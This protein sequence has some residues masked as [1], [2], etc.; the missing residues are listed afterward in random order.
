M[1]RRR[2]QRPEL[3]RQ[4]TDGLDQRDVV[5]G[6]VGGQQRESDRGSVAVRAVPHQPPAGVPQTFPIR[7][8]G[9]GNDVVVAMDRDMDV[10]KGVDK[11]VRL[12]VRPAEMPVE[13]DSDIGPEQP[14]IPRPPG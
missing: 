9:R 6:A 5:P 8:Q 1:Q 3:V 4:Q 11:V 2:G 14:V 13:N 12:R 10:S 7:A